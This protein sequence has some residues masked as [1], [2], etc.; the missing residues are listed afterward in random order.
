M[1][2]QISTHSRNGFIA[3]LKR[4]NYVKISELIR[5]AAKKGATKKVPRKKLPPPPKK[6]DPGALTGLKLPRGWAQ[7]QF[8]FRVACSAAK[9]GLLSKYSSGL[10]VDA[11][12]LQKEYSFEIRMVLESLEED[13]PDAVLSAF[14]A[15]FQRKGYKLEESGYG[16]SIGVVVASKPL[17][18][19]SDAAAIEKAVTTLNKELIAFAKKIKKLGYA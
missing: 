15:D 16:G 6:V 9:L 3:N 2:L 19:S 13:I 7:Y 1:T 18:S 8:P 14:N 5:S 4:E 17:P 12:I 11:L 10:E